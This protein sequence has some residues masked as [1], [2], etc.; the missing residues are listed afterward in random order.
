MGENVT[1]RGLDILGLSTGTQLR[2]GTHAV[3]E[4]TGLRN[5]C[6]QIE[7]FMPG[8]LAAVIGRAADGSILRKAG[9]MCVVL[10]GGIV[11]TG[12]TVAILRSP[13]RHQ[14][15]QPV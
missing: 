11:R 3:V 14:P 8:L 4:V 6:S 2:L 15:L 10:T 13:P 12:D 5:P 7:R 1:T 9:V